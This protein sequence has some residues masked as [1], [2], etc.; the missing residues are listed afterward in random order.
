MQ[1]GHPQ[2]IG[3]TRRVHV[4][5]LA[6][7]LLLRDKTRRLYRGECFADKRSGGRTEHHKAKR[8]IDLIFPGEAF[9]SRAPA[10]AGVGRAQMHPDQRVPRWWRPLP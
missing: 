4:A 5:Q 3:E 1:A 10:V 6:D 2:E 8:I 7:R 9:W